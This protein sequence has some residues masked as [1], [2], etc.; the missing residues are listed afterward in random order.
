L[1][2]ELVAAL[3]SDNRIAMKQ[4][5]SLHWESVFDASFRKVGDESVQA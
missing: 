3:R 5:F 1:S 4:I 2:E